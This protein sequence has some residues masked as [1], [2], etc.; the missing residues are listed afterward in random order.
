[1]VK[2]IHRRGMPEICMKDR[3]G[4]PEICMKDI[5]AILFKLRKLR[6]SS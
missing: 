1:V 3:R 5:G 4:M 6:M 2:T